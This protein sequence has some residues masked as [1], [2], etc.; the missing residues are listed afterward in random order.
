MLSRKKCA[1]YIN[2]LDKKF[3]VIFLKNQKI[4]FS[5][6]IESVINILGSLAI[7]LETGTID[8]SPIN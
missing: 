7:T 2:N 6:K 1:L 4:H 3:A 8:I 5:G